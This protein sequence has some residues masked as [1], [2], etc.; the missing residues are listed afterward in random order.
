[1]E[2]TTIRFETSNRIA[3]ITLNRP[4]NMNAFNI[5]M[6]RELITAFE[7]VALDNEIRVVILTGQGRAF[8][9]G[10]DVKGVDELLGIN[11]EQV[12]ANDIMK[13]VTRLVVTIRQAPKPVVAVLNGVA[14]GAS[15]NFALACD[16]IIA[17]EKARL[18]ENFINIGLIP[19]GGGTFFLLERIGYQRAAEIFFTGKILNA[20]EALELG[21]YNCVVPPEDLLDKAQEF[22][23]ELV[24]KPPRAIAA[25]KALLNRETIPRLRGYLE[26]EAKYQRLMAATKDAREG[27]TA[28]IE[29]RK[30]TFIGK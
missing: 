30:A 29:K 21:L 6:L 1:M 9:A 2:F 12:E 10:A 26:D 11:K 22:A 20:E 27:I 17:S 24:E 7:T 13:L 3:T 18:A 5:V 8:S 19:D 16:I 14:A 25:G 4:D 28:F 23:R 15:A